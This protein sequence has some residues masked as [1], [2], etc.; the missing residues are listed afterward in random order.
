MLIFETT[1]A[2]LNHLLKVTTDDLGG[3]KGE[4][5]DIWATSYQGSVAASAA[6]FENDKFL[7]K[8]WIWMGTNYFDLP[9]IC[10]LLVCKEFPFRRCY[11]SAYFPV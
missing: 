3:K 5:E 7:N 4:G 6:A 1:F 8:N 10:P 9:C 11:I 2:R